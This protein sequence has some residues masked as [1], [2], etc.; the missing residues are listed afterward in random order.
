MKTLN[1]AFIRSGQLSFFIHSQP[2]TN[3]FLPSAMNRHLAT[4][5]APIGSY[6]RWD[7]ARMALGSKLQ[8]LPMPVDYAHDFGRETDDTNLSG[9]GPG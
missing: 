5:I 7:A 8:G 2:T 6:S 1:N 9:E 3:R 4:V